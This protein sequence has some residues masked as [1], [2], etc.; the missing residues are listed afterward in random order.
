MHVPVFLCGTSRSGTTVMKA[1]LEKDPRCSITDETHYF[2]DLRVRLRDAATRPLA[3]DEFGQAEEYFMALT[4]RPY[5]HG[6]VPG[7][8]WLNFGDLSRQLHGEP[9]TLDDLFLAYNVLYAA[10]RGAQWGGEKTPRHVFRIP[11]IFEACP[12]ARV[13]FML[14]DPSAVVA[15][16][17]DWK[18]LG[19]F[20]PDT[21]HEQALIKESSRTSGSYHPVIIALL[22]KAALRAALQARERYGAGRVRIQSYEQV[23]LNSE[24]ELASLFDWLGT[25]QPENM[26]DVPILNS[27]YEAHSE[28]GGFRT[29]T[30]SRWKQMLSAGEIRVVEQAS[31]A[32]LQEAGYEAISSGGRVGAARF[33]ATFVPAAIRAVRINS[34]RSGYLPAYVL[35][36][37]RL[38]LGR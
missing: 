22:W 26:N 4:H 3:P 5:G 18:G 8:G 23:A 31:G 7:K 1:A 33:W 30:V 34:V 10:H 12:E 15:S 6:G 9:A 11:E 28:G 19:G 16:Y 24:E 2:D 32:L 29:S 25:P 36:R 37:C 21:D 13:I 38:V 27:S 35:R 17:R 14:R 20:E